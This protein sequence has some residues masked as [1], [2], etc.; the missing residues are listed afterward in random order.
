M[1]LCHG[2]LHGGFLA[3]SCALHLQA[4]YTAKAN[5]KIS[6]ARGKQPQPTANEEMSVNRYNAMKAA[7]AAAIHRRVLPL[8]AAAVSPSPLTLHGRSHA[9][10]G[11]PAAVQARQV[12]V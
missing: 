12:G 5:D 4:K 8:S 6:E 7:A 10:H 9:E 2:V 1:S 11:C 3:S